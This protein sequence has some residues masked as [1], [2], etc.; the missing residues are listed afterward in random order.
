VGVDMEH[1]DFRQSQGIELHS[2][3]FLII[4]LFIQPA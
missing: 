1:A 4:G 2:F 3:D